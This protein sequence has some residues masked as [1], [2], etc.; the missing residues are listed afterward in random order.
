M[1]IKNI[2]PS[3]II[4][5]KD[6]P[7]HNEHILK[8]YFKIC[9]NGNKEILPPTPVIPL[10][11]GVP[12]LPGK[13]KKEKEYNQKMKDF[14]KKNKEIKYLMCDGSHKTTALAL[15]HNKINCIL[16]KTDSDMKEMRELV[17]T[18]DVFSMATKTTIK[19]ELNEK[20][21]HLKDAL[22]FETVQDKTKRMVKE[23][24]IP[25]FMIKY[26]KTQNKNP[27]KIL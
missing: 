24:V 12:L 8:I 23:K 22:F 14:L 21:N 1:K 9:K 16:L 13:T 6:F 7:V 11:V 19:A 18:G 10:Y 20:A 25:E 15:T 4:T 17:N 27:Q 3:A 26:Y 2:S 5:T